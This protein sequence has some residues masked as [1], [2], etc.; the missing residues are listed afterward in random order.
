MTN[1]PNNNSS[2]QNTFS[3][4]RLIQQMN[5][6]MITLDLAGNFTGV[7]AEAE[8]IFDQS[9]EYLIG[10]PFTVVLDPF[11]YEKAKLMIERTLE[12]GTVSEWEL[13][14]IQSDG[15]PILLGYTTTQ[16][17]D[18][19]G[20]VIGLGAIGVDQTSKLILT[21]HLAET[22]QQLEGTLLK[23]EKTFQAL[24]ETQTQLVHSEKMRSL[25]TLVAG[26][27]HE[28]NNP[29]AFVMNNLS[30]LKQMIPD[31]EGLF[32]AYQVL[33]ESSH[34]DLILQLQ[35]KEKEF[36][37]EYLWDDLKAIANESLDG[38]D[39]IRKIVLSLRTFSHMD[40][41]EL[42]L[43]DI[44]DGLKSTMQLIRPMC[45]SRINVVT[46]YGKLPPINCFPGELNQV[47]LNLLTNAIQAIEKDGQISVSTAEE[48]GEIVIKIK[49]TGIGMDES[50]MARLGEPFFTTK[51]VGSGTGLG[52]SISTS[53]IQ[54]HKGV[55]QFESEK[56][57]GTTAIVR[58]PIV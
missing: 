29:A 41:A 18:E 20:M 47:F 24:Q 5:T 27:A 48:N 36:G 46:E 19:S 13:N 6:T 12:E 1:K 10:K 16:I 39:R 56:G 8:K 31:L 40:E 53:I 32:D 9:A 21:D 45:K 11:S 52:L 22:N 35:Q 33:K 28:I 3:W 54:R 2:I 4:E 51:P 57:V 15:P 43:M 26:I 17:K 58:L 25:G 42:K 30:T 55:I 50:T 49:D 7:N 38:M 23:L 14:H 37:V 34:E 44:N